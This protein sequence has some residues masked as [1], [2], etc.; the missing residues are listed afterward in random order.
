MLYLVKWEDGTFALVAAEDDESLVCILDQLSDPTAASWQVYDGPLWL[1][2]PRIDADL[3]S[4][5]DLEPH[6]IGIG[7]PSAAETDDGAA[8][9]DEVL[10]AVH[11][12]VAALRQRA[13]E[14]DRLISREELA[15]AVKADDA[16]ALPFSV[17]GVPDGT[18]H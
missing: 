1:E 16:C 12:G 8:F 7:R 18:E 13:M 14:E 9:V 3:P 6:S 10:D 4:T 11:P 17:F 15:R 2:F 5:G